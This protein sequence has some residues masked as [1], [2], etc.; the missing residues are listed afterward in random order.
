MWIPLGNK[1]MS[2][3]DIR[4]KE[5]DQCIFCRRELLPMHHEIYAYS[6]GKIIDASSSNLIKDNYKS[7]TNKFDIC[8]QCKIACITSYDI[9][10]THSLPNFDEL[11][12]YLK[13]LENN[14]NIENMYKYM[15][16]FSHCSFEEMKIGIRLVSNYTMDDFFFEK[17]LKLF[18]QNMIVNI[19]YYV[20][21]T[22]CTSPIKLSFITT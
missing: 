2:D 7:S 20:P 13:F 10:L 14:D 3:I 4:F 12:N 18:K 8:I 9:K 21:S 15:G 1:Y 16:V 11:M 22:I 5:L 17:L 6:N 19:N